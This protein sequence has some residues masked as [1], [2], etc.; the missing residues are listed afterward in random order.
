MV[1]VYRLVSWVWA[2]ALGAR[3][4]INRTQRNTVERAHSQES[5]DFPLWKGKG[6]FAL[7]IET[8][9]IIFRSCAS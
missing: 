8:F 3:A 9:W 2:S 4:A 6:A 7:L 1:E 5:G